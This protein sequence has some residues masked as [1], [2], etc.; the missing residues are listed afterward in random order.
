MQVDKVTETSARGHQG[1]SRHAKGKGRQETVP[2][3]KSKIGADSGSTDSRKY[4]LLVLE[5][6]LQSQLT[7]TE[8]MCISR[9]V[10]NSMS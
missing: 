10:G 6:L 1:V 8:V 2:P 7:V 9:P 3:S 5:I 4:K